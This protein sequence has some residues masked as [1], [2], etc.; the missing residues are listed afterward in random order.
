[1]RGED[2]SIKLLTNCFVVV[3][4]IR[5]PEDVSGGEGRGRCSLL[6][7]RYEEGKRRGGGSSIE[8]AHGRMRYHYRYQDQYV[9]LVNA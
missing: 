7:Q 2:K 9:R 3:C 6:S 4:L 5:S 1:M 8:M